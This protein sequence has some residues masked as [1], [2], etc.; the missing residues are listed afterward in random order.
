MIKI[1]CPCGFSLEAEDVG[2]DLIEKL[3][4]EHKHTP[5]PPPPKYGTTEFW[6]EFHAVC[7]ELKN[8][9]KT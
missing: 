6:K 3:W 5:A 1:I 7:E 4:A 2:T 9:R 8:E